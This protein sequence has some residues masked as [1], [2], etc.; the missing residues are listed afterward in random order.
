MGANDG[1]VV[2]SLESACFEEAVT[3]NFAVETCTWTYDDY[4][5]MWDCACGLAWQ[6]SNDEGLAANDMNF[7]P[8]CGR[9]IVVVVPAVDDDEEEEDA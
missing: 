6:M 5:C 7:C 9:R 8:K 3:V 4:H 1:D 2:G